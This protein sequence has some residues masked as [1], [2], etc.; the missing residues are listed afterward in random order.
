MFHS[1]CDNH[2]FYRV[3]TLYF[4]KTKINSLQILHC[5]YSDYIWKL[6]F[7]KMLLNFIQIHIKQIWRPDNVYL[8]FNYNVFILTKTDITI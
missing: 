6:C 8:I 2:E 7:N 4:L 3:Y 1:F 5:T